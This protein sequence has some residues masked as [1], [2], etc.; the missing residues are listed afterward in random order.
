MGTLFLSHSSIDKPAVLR[1]AKD[2][3]KRGIHVWLDEWE[4]DVGDPITERIQEALQNARYVAVWLTKN[5]INSGWVT[6]EWHAKIFQE[7]S[8]KEVLV[9]PLLG[10]K[11]DIP[12]F[13]ADKKYADF[14]LSYAEG[15]KSLLRAISKQKTEPRPSIPQDDSATIYHYTQQFLKDLEG[16]EIP[17]PTVGNLKIIRALQS[18]ERSGKLLRLEGMTPNLPIRSI[19]DHILSIAYSAD[20]L[21]PHVTTEIFGRDRVELARVIAYHDVCEVIIG[22]IPQYTKLNRTKRSRA[23][24]TAEIRLSQLPEGEPE[25]VT[26]SFIG[27]FLQESE[28]HSL[29]MAIETLNNESAVKKFFYALDKI[30]PI[31]AVWRYINYCREIPNFSINEFLSRMRHFFE[32]P[33]V[34]KA[35]AKNVS[36]PKLVDLVDQLQSSENAKAY[37]ADQQIFQE[38]LFELPSEAVRELIEGREILFVKKRKSRTPC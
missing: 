27:L 30:D 36:D 38:R 16:S 10:E 6:K 2:L 25:R 14:N 34:R 29:N 31:I 5:S 23:R 15:L 11:C 28:R 24:V 32:N 12:F 21:M 19:Y 13:L 37:F 22:D 35:V 4:I 17:I 18:L 33:R 9:L 7:I 20:C 8:S 1:L 3:R 26:N